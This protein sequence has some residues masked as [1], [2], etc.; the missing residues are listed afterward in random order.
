MPEADGPTSESEQLAGLINRIFTDP[1][2]AQAMDSDPEATLQAAGVELN[3]AQ[4]A[5]L[6]QVSRLEVPAEIGTGQTAIS[7]TRPVVSVLT[8][9]TKPLVK[10][11]TDSI[12]IENAPPEAA[13]P[14]AAPPEAGNAPPEAGNAPPEA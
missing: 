9:G 11:V 3:E 7:W 5:G 6:A 4:R 13:P 14:E 12:V 10:V 1:E 2:F 8:N